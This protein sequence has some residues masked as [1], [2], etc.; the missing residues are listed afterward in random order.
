M[1]AVEEMNAFLRGSSGEGLWGW[2][3]W[4]VPADRGRRFPWSWGVGG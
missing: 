2:G 4:K 3:G 1:E